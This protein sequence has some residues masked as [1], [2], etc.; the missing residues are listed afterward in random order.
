MKPIQASSNEPSTLVVGP[1][2]PAPDVPVQELAA[3]LD[4]V[5]RE[6]EA[7]ALDAIVLT[8]VKNTQYFLDFRSNS[9]FFNSRP[10]F[11]LITS[12]DLIIFAA[13]YEQAFIDGK[14]R[15]FTARYY[16]GYINEGATA[17]ADVVRGLF[18]GKSP[19]IAIDYG[20]EMYGRGSLTL[21]DAL[22]ELSAGNLVSASPTLWRVREVKTRFE[23]ELKRTA[24][25]I[26][27][28]AFNQTIARAHIGITEYEMWRMM[29]AQTFLNGADSGDPCPL[30][31]SKGDFNYG[32]PASARRLE[33]GHYIWS[34]FRATYGGYSA[35]RNRI[36]RAGEPAPW[37][38]DTYKAIRELTIEYCH[39]V[40]PGMTCSEV[41]FLGEK[42]WEP[43]AA[44]NKFAFQNPSSLSRRYGHSSGFDIVEVP[45]LGPYDHTVIKPGM[46]LHLE[47]KL[48]RDGAVFQC[49]EVF[50]VLEDGIE[51]LAP[52][53]PEDLPI[54]R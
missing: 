16:D 28:D 14:P 5:R 26:C 32:R 43:W 3:R 53:S 1:L 8:D 19:K 25:A 17:V 47:P 30:I 10:F 39:A 12:Q 31:F 51:F 18:K 52:L 13:G 36:A 21:V 48:Q 20:E 4:S 27:D 6:M 37:E 54:V 45:S 38:R 33:E 24:F 49:E 15:G 11:T 44:G 7:D 41:F 2:P 22:R 34:D 42:L 46:I 40:R 50:Y 9:W 23:A 29:Q 35:D